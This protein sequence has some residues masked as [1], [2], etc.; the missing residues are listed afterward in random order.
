MTQFLHDVFG[1][2]STAGAFFVESFWNDSSFP[3]IGLS[4]KCIKGIQSET[5]ILVPRYEQRAKEDVWLKDA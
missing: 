3:N 2:M 5:K 4:K 1:Y